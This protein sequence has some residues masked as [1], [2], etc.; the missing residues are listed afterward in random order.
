MPSFPE[1]EF[2]PDASNDDP[3]RLKPDVPATAAPVRPSQT[4]ARP[5]QPPYQAPTQRPTQPAYQPQPQVPTQRPTPPPR[6]VPPTT[7]RPYQPQPSQNRPNVVLQDQAVAIVPSACPAAMNCTLIDYCTS[8]GVISKTVV[9][10]TDFQKEF[11]VPMTDCMI[12]PSRELGKCCRDPDYTDPWPVGRLGMYNADE[13]NA[14][15]DSGAYKPE[16][17]NTASSRQVSVRVAPNSPNLAVARPYREVP[18]AP[19]AQQPTNPQPIH[20]Q[21]CGVRNYVSHF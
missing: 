5:T 11:R 6:V 4:P 20:A 15:F 16:S 2:N 9:E 14:V 12:M 13:L 17:Q 18:F 21:T 19:I 10:L 1:P 8:I 3:S 7:Q